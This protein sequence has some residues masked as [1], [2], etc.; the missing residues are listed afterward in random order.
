MEDANGQFCLQLSPKGDDESSSVEDSKPAAK[1][2]QSNADNEQV[3][4]ELKNIR[5]TMDKLLQAKSS[6]HHAVSAELLQMEKKALEDQ[7]LRNQELSTAHAKLE[8]TER[9]P[10]RRSE[11][12]R[13]KVGV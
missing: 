3:A 1:E 8:T 13:S 4:S 7:I 11:G 2:V 6:E 9:A 10:S 5:E 12:A